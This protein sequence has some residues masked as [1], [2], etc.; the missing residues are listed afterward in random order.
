MDIFIDL[1]THCVKAQSRKVSKQSESFLA[2]TRTPRAG[3]DVRVFGV[4][5]TAYA[6]QVRRK[7]IDPLLFTSNLVNFVPSDGASKPTPDQIR[8]AI[9]GHR[10]KWK[11]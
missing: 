8:Q 11:R 1:L 7:V 3:A 6:Y 4:E 2:S 5:R 10:H 9:G